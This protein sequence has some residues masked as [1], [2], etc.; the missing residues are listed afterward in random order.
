[1][2]KSG[3]CVPLLT[4]CHVLPASVVWLI[5]PKFPTAHASVGLSARTP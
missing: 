2:P 4:A 5:A 1:M 3:S